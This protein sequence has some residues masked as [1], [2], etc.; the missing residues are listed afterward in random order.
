MGSSSTSNNEKLRGDETSAKSDSS[1]P[2]ANDE[3]G[4]GNRT[5]K[6]VP[7]PGALSISMRPS[8][9]AASSWLMASPNPLPP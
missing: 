3:T 2:M 1:R 6:R 7:S 9:A 8:I 5:L 4:N